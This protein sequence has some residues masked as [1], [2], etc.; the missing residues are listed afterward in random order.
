VNISWN[1]DGANHNIGTAKY[2]NTDPS[3]R[4]QMTGNPGIVFYTAPAGVAGELI[5]AWTVGL[6]N[7]IAGLVGIGTTTPGAKLNVVHNDTTDAVRITQ[8]GSGNA[9]VVEDSTNPD[10]TPFIV[11]A[12]GNVGIGV[13]SSPTSKLHVGGVMTLGQFQG[14]Q[15]VD[16]NSNTFISGGSSYDN[17]ANIYLGGPD[18]AGGHL[19]ISTGAGATN[20][21]RMRVDGSGNVGIG[22]TDPQNYGK[23]AVSGSL[24][25]SGETSLYNPFG[26]VDA[27]NRANTYI[28]FGLGG[29]GNDW[30]YL[31]EIGTGNKLELALDL[32]DD[33]SD[34]NAGQAFSIRHL[35][36]SLTPDGGAQTLFKV[37]HDGNV[38]IG[39]AIPTAKLH[40]SGDAIIS[41]NTSTDALRITQEGSGNALVVEDS[42]NPDATPFVVTA[43]GSVGI[44][45]VP[46]PGV[47]L[48]VVGGIRSALLNI[49]D[50]AA[51]TY[52]FLALN[53]NNVARWHVGTDND[54]ESGSN[55][56]SN[57]FMHRWSDNGTFLERVLHISRSTGNV[58]I[59]TSSPTE[60]LEVSGTVKATAF[61][62]PLTGNVTGNLTGNV[63]G[64]LTGTASAIADGSVS[65]AKIV[66][67]N[68]T[69]AKLASDIDASKLTTG[70]LPIA[71][72]ADD[73]VTDAKLSL[74]ANAGEIKKALNADNDPPIFACRAWV[75]FDGTKNTAGEA[76]TANTNRLIRGSGNVTSVLRN[77]A[78]DYTITFTTAMP[79]ANYAVVC[80]CKFPNYTGGSEAQIIV[81][82]TV[83]S[84]SSA[85][86]SA[87]NSSVAG[88]NDMD[89]VTVA[90]FR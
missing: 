29:S 55:A 58:G 39:T 71:R 67:A 69:N 53:T 28:A 17:G 60:R 30:A 20:T 38:G 21:E 59:N 26:A 70:T 5:A 62:G 76:S 89:I 48:E 31:R 2:F 18:V 74:A 44:G 9:L 40:V 22:L 3:M 6:C 61:S 24:F 32:H 82:P 8:E 23:L 45:T 36:S 88:M 50:G 41:A 13:G 35:A 81:I 14:I 46:L 56:G 47:K 34:V 11:T 79:D 57:F 63:T 64:N 83:L 7:T 33:G 65:T 42:T 49:I 37:N 75:N 54:A 80:A 4:L 27:A 25:L 66:D 87:G 12:D 15:S 68:V 52:R 84:S 78:G 43:D 77:G 51:A 86:F 85:R 72:I 16:R 73:S 1:V 10:S 90:I 19:I